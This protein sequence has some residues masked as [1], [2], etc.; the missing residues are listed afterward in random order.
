[1]PLFQISAGVLAASREQHTRGARSKH[2]PSSTDAERRMVCLDERECW[3]AARLPPLPS[4][5]HSHPPS[6]LLRWKVRARPLSPPAS[7]SQSVIGV[8]ACLSA[9]RSHLPPPLG[10]NTFALRLALSPRRHT[11]ASARFGREKAF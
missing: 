10:V 5:S 7:L 6:R 8:L 11:P 4:P 2:P 3:A 1:M 9:P